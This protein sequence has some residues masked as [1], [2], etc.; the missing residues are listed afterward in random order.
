MA[1]ERIRLEPGFVLHA[2][3]FRET[4]LLVE[5][6][7][8]R[9]GRLGMVA[10]GAR[11]ARAKRRGQLQPFRPLLLSWSGRGELVTL[12]EAEEAAPAHS[13]QG[14]RLVSGLYVNELLMRLTVRSDPHGELY[15]EYAETLRKLAETRIP[16]A[17]VLRIFEKRLLDL[18]GYGLQ[19]TLEARTHRP[20]QAD[21]LYRF[22][23]E[24]GAVPV[25]VGETGLCV[26]GATLLA[27]AAEDLPA[28]AALRES[29]ILLR[30]ALDVQLGGRP[31]RSRDL[32]GPPASAPAFT[33]EGYDPK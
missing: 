15:V 14:A 26:S 12:A 13:L 4:S 9:H 27:L 18:L 1:G 6:F 23:V 22:D 32:L 25:G 10:R 7:S 5:V 19:L 2:R 30:H 8:Q 3:P 33:A 28:G 17:P 31:L 29:K 21:R 11:G 16:L 24:A 20:V